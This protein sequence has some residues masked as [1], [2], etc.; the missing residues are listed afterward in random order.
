MTCN[1]QKNARTCDGSEQACPG[2]CSECG[3]FK[4]LSSE[5]V[6]SRSIDFA[7]SILYELDSITDTN[8]EL[9]NMTVTINAARL[10]SVCESLLSYAECVDDVNVK[11]LFEMCS[12]I[13]EH[14]TMNVTN[15]ATVH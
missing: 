9:E 15:V 8:Q 6:I 14:S 13:Q 2:D 3:E 1:D 4:P 10:A 7:V 11:E 12:I 5:A